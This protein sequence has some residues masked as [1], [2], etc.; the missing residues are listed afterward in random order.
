MRKALIVSNIL[1]SCLMGYY[2]V[3][4]GADAVIVIVLVLNLISC[5]LNIVCEVRDGKKED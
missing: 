5:I 1:S 4:K 2:A 3:T